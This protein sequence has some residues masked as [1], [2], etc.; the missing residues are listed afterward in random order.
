MS[1]PSSR[2]SNAE[3]EVAYASDHGDH[4]SVWLVDDSPLQAEVMRRQL[5][6]RHTVTV[7]HGADA[8]LERLSLGERP[9]LLVLD[10]LMPGMSGLEACRFVRA[11]LDSAEL[12]IVIIT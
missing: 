2:P 6:D 10:W 8:M 1:G 7:F 5:A 3:G 12:P 4:P 11:L 9:D